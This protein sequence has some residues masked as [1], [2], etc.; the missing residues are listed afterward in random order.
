MSHEKL[1]I[2]MQPSATEFGPYDYTR[3]GNPTRDVLE[4]YVTTTNRNL[5]AN[6]FCVLPLS[7]FNFSGSLPSLRK[8]IE[9]FALLVE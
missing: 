2:L 7:P 3:S 6:I 4:K 5:C 8:Q 1:Y 9:H